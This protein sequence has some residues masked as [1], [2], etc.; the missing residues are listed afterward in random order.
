[1]SK[2]LAR[3]VQ[4]V[5]LTTCANIAAA[6]AGGA[7]VAAP[8]IIV[9]RGSLAGREGNP[10]A[11]ARLSADSDHHAAI[12]PPIDRHGGMERRGGQPGHSGEAGDRGPVTPHC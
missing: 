6:L 2:A 12:C 9:A 8:G 7:T 11:K 10:H 1:M 5:I 4:R 3:S